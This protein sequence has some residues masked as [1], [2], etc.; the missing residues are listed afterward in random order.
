[1]FSVIPAK[2]GI[3][4]NMLMDSCFRRNDK[5]LTNIDNEFI[6]LN[7]LSF[8]AMLFIVYVKND[9]SESVFYHINPNYES[10]KYN[11]KKGRIL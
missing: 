4:S 8:H 9:K 2:A 7:S 3:Q 10:K 11:K 5:A 1:M 6:I